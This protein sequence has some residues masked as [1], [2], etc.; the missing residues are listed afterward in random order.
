MPSFQPPPVG[1]Y[2]PKYEFL[3]KATKK[4]YIKPINLG[5]DKLNSKK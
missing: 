4:C 5:Q 2:N 1:I 3:E